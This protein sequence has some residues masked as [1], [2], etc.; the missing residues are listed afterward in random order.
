MSDQP[1]VTLPKWAQ[2]R[3]VSG[4]RVMSVK[5]ANATAG[6]RTETWELVCG[7]VVPVST[8]LRATV[9]QGMSPLDGYYYQGDDGRECWA[10]VAEFEAAFRRSLADPPPTEAQVFGTVTVLADPAPVVSPTSV[11]VASP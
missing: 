10:G 9:P 3:V 4:D 8:F 11:V 5:V 7:S 2:Y 6:G 1:S